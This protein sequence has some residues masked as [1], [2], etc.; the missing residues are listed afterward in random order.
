MLAL[1]HARLACVWESDQQNSWRLGTV[2]S[3]QYCN[4]GNSVVKSSR[5][6][7]QPPACLWRP[8]QSRLCGPQHWRRKYPASIPCNCEG[9]NKGYYNACWHTVFILASSEGSLIFGGFGISRI[10]FT[11]TTFLNEIFF[12]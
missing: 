4:C 11:K 3:T 8:Q 7:L 5:M 2:G 1:T 10:L 12:F 6:K 9:F